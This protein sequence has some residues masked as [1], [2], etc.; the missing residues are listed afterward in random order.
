MSHQLKIAKMVIAPKTPAYQLIEQKKIRSNE[1]TMLNT[2][3]LVTK[4]SV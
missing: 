2:M 1:L 3:E 4:F